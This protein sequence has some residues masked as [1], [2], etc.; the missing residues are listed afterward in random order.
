[1]QGG[2]HDR[3][4]LGVLSRPASGSV[5]RGN[6]LADGLARL[7]QPYSTGSHAQPK[8]GPGGYHEADVSTRR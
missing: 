4:Q 5:G 6:P 8:A 7:L 3:A 2:Y 1:M